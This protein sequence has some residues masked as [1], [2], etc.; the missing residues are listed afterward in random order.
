MSMKSSGD[1]LF[2]ELMNMTANDGGKRGKPQIFAKPADFR[3]EQK[4]AHD[5]R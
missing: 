2:E 3:G 5:L 1:D 4:P